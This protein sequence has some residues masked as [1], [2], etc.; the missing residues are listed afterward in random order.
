MVI[1]GCVLIFLVYFV[2]GIYWVFRFS[3]MTLLHVRVQTI[4]RPFPFGGYSVFRVCLSELENRH[5]YKHSEARKSFTH[6]LHARWMWWNSRFA[7]A[8]HDSN[9]NVALVRYI[10]EL[11]TSIQYATVHPFKT[12]NSTHSFFHSFDWLSKPQMTV[13]LAV[14][15]SYRNRRI[16][17]V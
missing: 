16:K 4:E 3:S 12:M 11:F 1:L 8:R 10:E 14:F 2:F 17:S 7:E 15:A 13:C 9:L 5:Q 6:A